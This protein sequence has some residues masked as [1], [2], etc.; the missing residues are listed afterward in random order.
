[1]DFT[2]FA[3]LLVKCIAFPSLIIII[4]IKFMF[5]PCA[6]NRR[7]PL[8]LPSYRP[9]VFCWLA[10]WLSL[11]PSVS[12]Q[13]L[14]VAGSLGYMSCKTL[15]C[16]VCTSFFPYVTWNRSAGT[17]SW[18]R[19]DYSGVANTYDC[20]TRVSIVAGSGWLLP[21]HLLPPSL[22]ALL[23][24]TCWTILDCVRDTNTQL[25][26]EW[27]TTKPQKMKLRLHFL[28]FLNIM[29]NPDSDDDDDDKDDKGKLL[30]SSAGCLSKSPFTQF[31]HIKRRNSKIIKWIW[32]KLNPN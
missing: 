7:L 9:V 14:P 24:T 18:E 4:I 25:L 32:K 23:H 5:Q 19:R 28:I 8:S 30:T 6:E 1:M 16:F 31:H 12:L 17:L 22:H 20:L 13:L 11:L 29:N 2:I 26:S 10:V 3:I 27:T 21:C 15:Q